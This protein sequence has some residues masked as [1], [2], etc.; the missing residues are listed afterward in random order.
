MDT[1]IEVSVIIVNY[2]TKEL[3]SDCIESLYNATDSVR[4][5]IIVVD[6]ASTD[7]SEGFIKSRYP[8]VIWVNSGANI[9]FGRANNL[10]A[11]YAK[12]KYLFLLNSDTILKNNAIYMLHQY[13]EAYAE[14]DNVG[15]IGCWLLNDQE[16]INYSY[17]K[18]PT[19][20]S[21]ISYLWN[22]LR[23]KPSEI[24]T[25]KDV[26]F[27]TGADLFLS[28]D[29]YDKLGGFDSNIFMYY[30]ETDLQYRMMKLGLRRR[31]I[32]G[33]KIIHFE[34]GSFAKKGLSLNRFMMAQT[35][36]NYYLKKHYHG[37][38]Y[39]RYRF[40]LMIIRLSLFI[41]TDWNFSEKMKAYK[42][43]LNARSKSF[44]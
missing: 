24:P 32:T 44:V 31:L 9:G 1:K 2:N 14:M 7:G 12:G 21:E 3:L 35:S 13:M 20:K 28:K 41:T 18:F 30:E 11:K 19:P 42:L 15:A 33:P 8:D 10:G 27:V 29:R 34:G 17:G 36:Y 23:T 22:K 37:V 25:I 43:V 6:N 26:D 5:E 39:C 4:Y 40:V 38:K 16:K